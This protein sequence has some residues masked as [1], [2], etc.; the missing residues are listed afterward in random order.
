MLYFAF[1]MVEEKTGAISVYVHVM[2]TRPFSYPGNELPARAK[3][4]ETTA[5]LGETTSIS[6]SVYP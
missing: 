3:L 2:V 6:I 1:L 5:I 4:G